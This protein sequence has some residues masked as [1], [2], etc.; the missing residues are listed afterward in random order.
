MKVNVDMN[1][2]QSHGECVL[3]A[4]DVF[5]LGDDDVLTWTEDVPEDRRADMEA[6]V[7]A[8]PMMAISLED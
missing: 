4:P 7:N 1:L 8:C 5:D 3:V 2:C 6:A